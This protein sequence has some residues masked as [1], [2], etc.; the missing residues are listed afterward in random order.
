MLFFPYRKEIMMNAQTILHTLLGEF[1]DKLKLLSSLVPREARFPNAPGKIK[2]AIGMRRSGKT[3]FFYQQILKM[4]QEGV[5]RTAILYLNLEDDRLLPLE[6]QKLAQL[7]E[8]FYALYPEN[9]ERKCYLFLDEIQNVQNWPIVIRRLHDSKNAEIFLTGSSAKLLSKEIATN[10]RGRSLAVEIWPYS[11]HEYLKAKKI[12]IDRALFDKK[13]LD[14]LSQQFHHY[15]SEGGFP[16]ITAFDPDVKQKTLQ[17]YLDVA[18]Y[19]DLI[20]RHQIKNP[21]IIKYMILSMMH[22]V[23]KPFAINK[24][25]NDLKNQGYAISK[26]QLYQYVEHIEDAFLA[27]A[28]PIYDPSIRKVHSNPKKIYAIDTGMARA[29]TLEYEK[30]FGRLFENVVYLD[31]RRSGYKVNYYLTQE[32]YEIDFLAQTP[33]GKKKLFQVVW[34]MQDAKTQEREE[35]ALQ[36]G[37]KQL[38]IEGSIV[39]LES[40]LRQGLEAVAFQSA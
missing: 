16:E 9:H 19:R 40:Y 17:E 5:D 7:V 31:L 11:F 24:F 37:M 3:Y 6:E 39:T 36:A 30:D 28:V 10:L 20:E 35:R 23:G 21:S 14:K 1:Y 12:S 29:L 34:N 15:L 22:N 13:T 2:V 4:L 18:I 26:D 38:K 32:R 33:Q 8:A 27:F 25:Y